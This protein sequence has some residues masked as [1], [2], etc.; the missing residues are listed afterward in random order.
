MLATI[1]AAVA[2]SLLFLLVAVIIGVALL[3]HVRIRRKNKLR[4][5]TRSESVNPMY[6]NG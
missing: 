2:G 6:R 4:G 5:K 3:L 1:G